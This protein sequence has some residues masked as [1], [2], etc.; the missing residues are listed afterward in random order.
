MLQADTFILQLGVVGIQP[1]YTE[2]V[3]TLFNK[4][5]T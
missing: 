2:Y 1:F 3:L 4:T 5:V